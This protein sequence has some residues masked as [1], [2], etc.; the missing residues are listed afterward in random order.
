LILITILLEINE[1]KFSKFLFFVAFI[2]GSESPKM[3]R[4]RRFCIW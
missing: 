4:D 3:T 1:L 2:D